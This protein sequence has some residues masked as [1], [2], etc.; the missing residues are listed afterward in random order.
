MMNEASSHRMTVSLLLLEG[1]G[2]YEAY[3][4]HESRLGPHE[5]RVCCLSVDALSYCEDK[6]IPYVLPEDCFTAEESREWQEQSE[7]AI[8]GLVQQLNAYYHERVREHDGFRFDGGNYHYFRLY[9]FLNALHYRCFFLSRMIEK[10]RVDHIL[11]PQRAKAG[12]AATRFPVSLYT[13][14]YLDLCLHSTY[15][16]KVVPLVE[17]EQAAAHQRDSVKTAV[18]RL[19]STSMRKIDAVDRALNR[20]RANLP[21]NVRDTI[22]GRTRSDILLVGGAGPWRHVFNDRSLASRVEM[23]AAK[24]EFTRAGRMQKNWFA[25]WFKWDDRF[26]GFNLS[27]LCGQEMARVKRLS[28]G[29]IAGHRDTVE[30]V[31]RYK[32]LIYSVCPYPFEQYLLS[33]G[34]HLGIPRICYQHGEMSLYE[35]GLWSESSELLYCSHYFTFGDQVSLEKANSAREVTGFRRAISVGS[36]GLEKLRDSPSA[37]DGYILYAASKYLDYSAG[38]VPRHVDVHLF[39]NQELLIPY[40]ED[41]IQRSP[42][43]RVVWKLNPE[44]LTRQPV[45]ATNRV[46]V[47]RDEKTFTDLLPD[48]RI[49]ILDRPST[50]SLEACMTEKPLFV[51]MANRNW[52]PLPESLLRKRAVIA[53]TAEELVESID[54]YLST[55]YYPADVK[56]REFLR[57]YGVHLDDGEAARR[58]MDELLKLV[59]ETIDQ[60]GRRAPE[61][62]TGRL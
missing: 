36:A 8:K 22:L 6:N 14:C 55:G 23:V 34:K 21:A 33:V 61:V 13:N 45:T 18:R 41:V 30:R 11:I 24:E 39:R 62:I 1:A 52:Y 7:R 31:R 19:L 17:R 44:R 50:T 59:E 60:V 2:G 37:P 58:A 20:L 57:A 38:F 42:D 5:L 35:S 26:C 40:F 46:T 51:S 9:H 54:R 16:D 12:A 47:I 28:E 25:D 15:K 27:A 56:N 10:L 4:A 3:L 49:V 43:T 32:A 29:M 48:A 53:Y